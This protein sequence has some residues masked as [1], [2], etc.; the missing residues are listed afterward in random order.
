M[1]VPDEILRALGSTG[2]DAPALD[3]LV[4]QQR[5]QRLL[6]LR[7]VLDAVAEA[8]P[9]VLPPDAARTVLADWRLLA[10]ADA[11]TRP[12]PAASCTTR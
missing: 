9:A 3:L 6:T 1:N 10:A 8:P 11:P 5:R 2:G 7:A 4:A 12:P